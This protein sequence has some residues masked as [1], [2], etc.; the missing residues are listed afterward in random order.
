M[1]REHM[2]SKEVSLAPI[3][4]LPLATFRQSPHR[5]RRRVSSSIHRGCLHPARKDHRKWVRVRLDGDQAEAG[6]RADAQDTLCGAEGPGGSTSVP[7]RN[8][9]ASNDESYSGKSTRVSEDSALVVLENVFQVGRHPHADIRQLE[10]PER[11]GNIGSLR[12]NESDTCSSL[13][14]RSSDY[15]SPRAQSSRIHF[16]PIRGPS[17]HLVHPASRQFFGKD[18]HTFKGRESR[19]SDD[20]L[21]GPQHQ[22]GSNESVGEASLD[23]LRFS[24]L[25]G[26]VNGKT[27]G[28]YGCDSGYISTLPLS[29]W[30]SRITCTSPQD[31]HSHGTS[32]P[33]LKAAFVPPLS[34]DAVRDLSRRCVQ[35]PVVREKLEWNLRFVTDLQVYVELLGPSIL[36]PQTPVPSPS[37]MAKDDVKIYIESNIMEPLPSDA[38]PLRFAKAFTVTESKLKDGVL[39]SLRRPIQW[40]LRLNQELQQVLRSDITLS[41]PDEKAAQV[42]LGKFAVVDDFTRSFHQIILH[43]AVRNLFVIP[44]R[45]DGQV[46]FLRMVRL[47]MGFVKA[48]DVMNIISQILTYAIVSVPLSNIDTHIDNTRILG[49]S[50]VAVQRAQMEFRQVCSFAGLTL[51]EDEGSTVH[52]RGKYCGIVFDYLL[53]KVCLSEGFLLKLNARFK[54]VD[55]WSISDMK[56]A[57]GMLFYGAAVLAAPVARWYYSIKYYSRRCSACLPDDAPAAVWKSCFQEINEWAEYLKTNTPVIPPNPTTRPILTVFTDSSLSGWGAVIINNTTGTFITRG[58]PFHSSEHITLKE[59]RAVFHTLH[60]LHTLFS[61]LPSPIVWF[62]DN[63]SC[64]GALRKGRS[65]SFCLNSLVTSVKRLIPLNVEIR[66]D[67]VPTRHNL[68]DGPSRARW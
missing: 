55:S 12:F 64:L 52:T 51:N 58:G 17:L 37:P 65:R 32:R 26:P 11:E 44:V 42:H 67:F 7:S 41:K 19:I 40:P 5:R 31:S 48:A 3:F 43:P 39:V 45:V 53:K 8:D 24:P 28:E 34:I 61:P 9:G 14:A 57:F 35:D 2:V 36:C 27:Q 1:G 25:A 68:A 63:T 62:I 29:S 15:C 20:C 22:K 16:P 6:E 66:F 59:I 56:K 18:G 47:P 50:V 23:T 60:I 10:T 13:E 33:R 49:D 54:D 46:L 30:G 38:I 4:S 21:F